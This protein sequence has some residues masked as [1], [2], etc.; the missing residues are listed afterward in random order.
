MDFKI[1]DDSLFFAHWVVLSQ[2]SAI[3]SESGNSYIDLYLENREITVLTHTKLQGSETELL[4]LVR[5]RFSLDSEEDMKTLHAMYLS[6]NPWICIIPELQ[7]NAFQTLHNL[8]DLQRY[9]PYTERISFN[10]IPLAFFGH[11]EK[12]RARSP[13][14]LKRMEQSHAIVVK[15][16]KHETIESVSRQCREEIDAIDN[17]PMAIQTVLFSE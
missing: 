3:I 7:G 1:G 12:E 17:A 6:D 4:P 9:I 2:S 15:I 8:K 5:E 10:I 13:K 11:F 16:F 14:E